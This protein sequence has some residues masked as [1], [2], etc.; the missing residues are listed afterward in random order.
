MNKY[1]QSSVWDNLIKIMPELKN[2][3]IKSPDYVDSITAKSLYNIWRTGN[4]NSYNSFFKKPVTLGQEEVDR[5]KSSGLIQVVGDNLK[6][7]N[8]GQKI[9]KIMILGDDRSIFEDDGVVIDYNK[10]L[11]Q[12]KGIKTAKKH[13]VASSWWDQFKKDNNV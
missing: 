7:T 13:R 6:I 2:R 11:N 9:I 10:A 1:G 5:M 12:T 8:K 3:I 4:N